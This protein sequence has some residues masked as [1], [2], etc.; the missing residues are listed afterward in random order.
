MNGPLAAGTVPVVFGPPRQTYENFTPGDSF[1]HVNSF[2]DAKALADFLLQLGKNIEAYT[3]H[4]RW[5]Q[6]FSVRPPLIKQNQ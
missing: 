2:P 1:I 3:R 4:F 6:Y 5:R